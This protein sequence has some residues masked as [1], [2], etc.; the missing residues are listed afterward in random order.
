MGWRKERRLG[1]VWR[2][3]R[4]SVLSVSHAKIHPTLLDFIFIF[5]R[6]D[7]LGLRTTGQS[8]FLGFLVGLGMAG[9][10]KGKERLRSKVE[11]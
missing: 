11:R 10:R 8:V 4:Y 1:P 6:I 9:V 3:G 7:R 5:V 2:R